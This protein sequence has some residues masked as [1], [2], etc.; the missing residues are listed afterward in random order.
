[1]KLVTV[2][3]SPISRH[4]ISLRS[5]LSIHYLFKESSHH[6]ATPEMYTVHTYVTINH[7]LHHPRHHF[8]D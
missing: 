6:Y 4:F 5:T 7:H 8:L 3:F 2:Q 1:M